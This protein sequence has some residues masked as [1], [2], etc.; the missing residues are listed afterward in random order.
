MLSEDQDSQSL[1]RMNDTTRYEDMVVNK[2]AH[3]DTYNTSA[4]I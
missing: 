1:K 2:F 4:N 3:F